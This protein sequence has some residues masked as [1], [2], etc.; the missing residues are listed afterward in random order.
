MF[1]L[2]LFLAVLVTVIL[3]LTLREK[4]RHRFSF[5]QVEAMAQKLAA[6]PY[7]APPPVLPDQ[8]KKLT[9]AQELGIYMRENARLWRKDGLPFQVDFYHVS[10][11]FPGGPKLNT[12][13]YKGSHPLRYSPAQFAF[14]N[15]T[16]NPPLPTD[17][18]F[19]GFYLRYPINKEGT[20]DGFFSVGSTGSS[21]GGNYFRTFAKDQI[22]GLSARGLALNTEV[23][24]K[25]EEFPQF[26]EW[27]LHKPAI[28][29]TEIVLD[30]LM[31]S[32]SVTGAYGFKVHPG[33]VTSV[34]VH[35][36]L[37]FRAP[38]ERL[39]IAPFSSMYL[40][41]ENFG[42]Q[43]K[44]H[45]GD[46]GHPEKHDS[47]GILMHRGSGEWVWKPLLQV[48]QHQ[49]YPIPDDNPEGFGLLQR[50]RDFQH[51]QD[52]NMKYNVR[53]SAWVIP[54]GKWGKGVI[55]LVQLPTNNTDTDNVVLFWTPD[56]KVQA[57]DRMTLDY[58]INFY[59]NDADL[60]PL[61]YC[62]A[63]YINYPAEDKPKPVSPAIPPPAE[64]KPA[65]GAKG[66]KAVPA[67]PPVFVGP[68]APPGPVI[69]KGTV[70]VEFVIDFIGHGID[71]IPGDQP[72]QIDLNCSPDGTYIKVKKV[73]KNDY[74]HL[75]R[76][77]FT[78]YPA[79]PNVPTEIFCRL[80]RDGKPIT[81]TWTYTWHQPKP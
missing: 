33:A 29:A 5:T 19:A 72:P 46:K 63:T 24:G 59:M 71:S 80:L 32:P 31:D 39:G 42:E 41:G 74:D 14:D 56:K 40:Y 34:D 44:D 23:D 8:L 75:W 61:A 1:R 12:V 36:T 65:K 77:T 54:K 43:T 38:V 53:P 4:Y 69:P 28:N 35:A 66:A 50:D 21:A 30:A 49:L 26:S 27:W 52:L 2:H 45:F 70:P 62:T 17:L 76:V 51:Y 18:P 22:Y 79:K 9:P 13:D 3:V 6:S 81:E 16:F 55:Q 25:P 10:K 60:P 67:K 57:G 7:V 47:D 68:P 20:L 58:T 73:E 37:F 64:S 11:D 78:M 15:L 48:R